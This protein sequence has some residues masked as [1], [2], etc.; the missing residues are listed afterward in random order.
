LFPS[1]R[2]HLLVWAF[3][4][5]ERNFKKDGS[6]KMFDI[7]C[8]KIHFHFENV[9]VTAEDLVDI[10]RAVEDGLGC[11]K[12][13]GRVPKGRPEEKTLLGRL[14]RFLRIR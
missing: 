10:E 12:C 7:F 6:E 9:S 4:Q 11:L 5:P 1:K 13:K 2:A 3:Y 8:H 14:K